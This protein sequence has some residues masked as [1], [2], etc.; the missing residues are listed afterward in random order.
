[1]YPRM[2]LCRRA[3]GQ[4]MWMGVCSWGVGE[5]IVRVG[6]V[7]MRG[8]DMSCEQGVWQGRSVFKEGVWTGRCGKGECGW[9][10]CTMLLRQPV[11]RLVHILLECILVSS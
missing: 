10:G 1:M 7:D 4:V 9:V 8:E 6:C 11:M 3:L 5:G 2:H